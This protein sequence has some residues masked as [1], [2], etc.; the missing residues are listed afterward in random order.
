MSVLSAPRA[1]VRPLA[2]LLLSFAA[3]DAL[4]ASTAPQ[5]PQE[6]HEPKDLVPRHGT[7]EIVLHASRPFDGAAGSTNP[8]TDLYVDARVTSPSGRERLLAG[9][10]DGD[11]EGGAFGDVFRLRVYA[12]EAGTWTWTTESPDPGLDGQSGSFTVGGTLPGRW[13]HGGLTVRPSVPRHFTHLDGT[14]VFLAGKFL[15]DAAEGRLSRTH[16]MFSES[17]SDADRQALLER[18]TAQSLNKV[19][20]YLANLGDYGGSEPTT[21][22]VGSAARNDK[23]RYA[24]DRWHAYDAWTKRMRDL[25]LATEIWFFADDSAFG[26]LSHQDR[27]R[28]ISYAM[29]RLS[30]YANT[31]FVLALEWQEGW[32]S[33]EVHSQGT[34]LAA[35]NAWERPVSVHG[36]EGVFAFPDA[37]WASFMAIQGGLYADPGSI[38]DVNLENLA[39]AVK[40]AV[41]EELTMGLED[42][43]SRRKTWSA[44]TAGVASLGTGA[45]FG[46][47]RRLLEEVAL[48]RLSPHDAF[49]LT[50][51]ATALA[52]H[53]RAYVAYLPAGGTVTVD[54]AQATGEFD[55]RWLNP[56]TGA[57]LPVPAIPAG[58]AR[59]LRAPDA[60]DWVLHLVRRCPEGVS[61]RRVRDLAVARD[62]EISWTPI[63]E[64]GGYDVVVGDLGALR[65]SGLAGSV[66]GCVERNGGD[67]L[68]RH[69][70]PPPPGS[71]QYFLLR[72]RDCAGGA[73]TYDLAAGG[74][75]APRDGSVGLSGNDCPP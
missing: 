63:A 74:Q 46:P 11:G 14:P 40:P 37:P 36:V 3:L 61:S 45:G 50:G 60:A 66:R 27:E 24:L 54:L 2:R 47:L 10:F 65:A 31:L 53:D 59:T 64:A 70:D 35:E 4:G 25:G 69:P 42:L 21:P 26:D 58:G 57:M 34:D 23:A 30:A 38:H 18:A 15:D 52:E 20:V 1:A 73:R 22:W 12:D 72:A 68:A 19:A 49:I 56:R 43:E 9:F 8:F 7:A 41:D 6:A 48:E 29:A 55:A 75:A 13:G 62:G 71:G 16:P 44:L 67:A 39:L 5:A 32:T 33:G 28:L 51:E 17:W